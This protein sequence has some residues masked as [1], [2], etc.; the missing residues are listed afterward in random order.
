MA[1]S[2]ARLG[3]R[4]PATSDT[5]DV[6]LDI[7]ASMDTLDLNYGFRVCTS[8]T[9]PGTPFQGQLIYETDT[10]DKY[11]YNGTSWWPI[12]P[13][14]RVKTADEIVNNSSTLQ[15]DDHLVVPVT[16]SSRYLWRA[17]IKLTSATA[18]DFKLDL[19]LP[20][21]S[22]HES[23]S[24]WWHRA[25]AVGSQAGDERM[26]NSSSPTTTVPATDGT[27]TAELLMGEIHGLIV[28]AGTAGSVQVRWAQNAANVSDTTVYASSW[29]ELVRV[30]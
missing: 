14:T 11:F 2:T 27:T 9:R 30:S 8:G 7:A 22:S 4:K 6:A 26:F 29:M 24:Q 18:A 21:G 15:N 16:A 10:G 12:G 19:S 13:L 23:V 5:V 25:A 3:L 20:A 1:T 28:V 17:F